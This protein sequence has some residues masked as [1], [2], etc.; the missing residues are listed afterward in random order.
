MEIAGRAGGLV[1]TNKVSLRDVVFI[2]GMDPTGVDPLLERDPATGR[3]LFGLVKTAPGDAFVVISNSGGNGSVVE[4]ALAVKEAGLPLVAIT[5]VAHSS[6]IQSRHPSGKR[7][8]EI[9]DIVIDNLAPY[10][11][12]ILDLPGGG[13]ACGISSVTS[14]TAAQMVVA[15]ALA[16]LVADGGT[17]PVYL[18]ANIPD[19]DEHNQK[20]ED[21]YAGRI[22]RG[23]F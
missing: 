12:A 23:P 15:E 6:A 18:S 19:A 21:H 17:P 1:G 5:S 4:F 11:D 13:K 10:G 16:R 7:L 3:Q 20:L 8:F 14:A 9:A 22:H 2:G